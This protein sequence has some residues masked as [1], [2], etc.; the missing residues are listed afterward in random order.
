MAILEGVKKRPCIVQVEFFHVGFY[1]F[2]KRSDEAVDVFSQDLYERLAEGAPIKTVVRFSDEGGML[3][4][5]VSEWGQVHEWHD[6]LLKTFVASN[7]WWKMIVNIR[8]RRMAWKMSA[9]RR[10]ARGLA[11]ER[12]RATIG[13]SHARDI[14]IECRDHRFRK[15]HDDELHELLEAALA[16]KGVW[17]FAFE[18]NDLLA[19]TNALVGSFM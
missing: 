13:R 5:F 7:G 9:M 2:T 4:D 11:V 6:S 10:E 14:A 16:A 19:D 1:D 3:A 18:P 15:A 12:L 17:I 8:V